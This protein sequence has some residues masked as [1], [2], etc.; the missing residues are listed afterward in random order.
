MGLA[1]VVFADLDDDLVDLFFKRFRFF[2]HILY[3]LAFLQAVDREREAGPEEESDPGE[4]RDNRSGGFK[5]FQEHCLVPFREVIEHPNWLFYG[6]SAPQCQRICGILPSAVFPHT[7]FG[8][9]PLSP[10]KS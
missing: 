10:P 8:G 5:K 6:I 3:G 2:R 9:F 4:N 7:C 1:A